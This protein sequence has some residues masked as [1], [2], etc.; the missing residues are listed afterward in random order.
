M[1][2]FSNFIFLL[3]QLL[4][5]QSDDSI[6]RYFYRKLLTTT[7]RPTFLS[8]FSPV[9]TKDRLSVLYSHALSKPFYS[10]SQTTISITS[11]HTLYHSRRRSIYDTKGR[12][13]IDMA[14]IDAVREAIIRQMQEEERCT[15]FYKGNV[16]QTFKLSF[17]H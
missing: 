5:V 11:M 17:D 9:P 1:K 4:L 13:S 2:Y 10:K 8:T 7:N 16:S 14:E 12:H 6:S 15:Y 3:I